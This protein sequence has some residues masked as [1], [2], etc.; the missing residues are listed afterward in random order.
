[1]N[2][3]AAADPVT[4]QDCNYESEME[5]IAQFSNDNRKMVGHLVSLSIGGEALEADFKFGDPMGG[6]TDKVPVCGGLTYTH[7]NKKPGGDVTI[8]GRVSDTNQGVL[9]KAIDAKD[10]TA[11]V[12]FEV[13]WYK[14]SPKTQT[15]YKCYDFDG[16]ALKG[17]ISRKAESYAKDVPEEDYEQ[18]INYDFQLV[19][20][21]TDEVDQDIL[22]AY[23]PNLKEAY[24]YGQAVGG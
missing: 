17:E 2:M 19:V 4:A 9:K 8:R 11:K 14:Y 7:W 24:Q 16:K 18:I 3:M 12:E 21:G 22:V 13:I 23:N 1:M 20:T 5:W 15:Y 6:A 10:K